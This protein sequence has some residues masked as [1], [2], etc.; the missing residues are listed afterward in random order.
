MDD[1]SL[2]F[3]RRVFGALQRDALAQVT[4]RFNIA[5]EDGRQWES[6]YRALTKT[7]IEFRKLLEALHRA[8]L[9]EICVALELDSSGRQNR[10]FIERILA[11]GRDGAEPAGDAS[12]HE[13][14]LTA[15]RVF[16][17]HGRSLLWRELDAF[18]QQRLNLPTDEFNSESVAGIAT[19]ERLKDMLEQAAF[20]FLVLT[21]EDEHGDGKLHAR[22]NVIHETGLFQ[23]RLGFQRAILLM[24][25]G[26][27]EFS[28]VAGL[29][30]IRFPPGAIMAASEEIRGVLKR[31]G[32]LK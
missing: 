17:G 21:A 26:C 23:G 3:R 10:G 6:H 19:V 24:E 13:P 14:G 8:D 15:R 12:D 16:I 30:Q 5:V 22:E 2:A 31:E 4:D 9:Q 25:E 11:A 32:L 28:N 27:A 29:S 1:F 18:I 7:K 20:A